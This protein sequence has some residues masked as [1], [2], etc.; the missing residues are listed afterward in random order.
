MAILREAIPRAGTRALG[1]AVDIQTGAETAF[2]LLCTIEKWP[3]WLSFLRSAELVN[4]NEPLGLGAE[5]LLRS[6]VPGDAEQLF[7][8]DHF[9]TNHQLSLVGAYSVR[10]RLDFRIERKT[11]RCK[12]HARVEYPA[13]GGRIAVLYDG[14]RAGRK[15]SAQLEDSLVHFKHLAEYRADAKDELLADF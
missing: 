15:L 10:R 1:A 7:E 11:T 9:I 12:L 2:N 13:Y 5:V 8:V 6:S 3:L 4:P 14:V